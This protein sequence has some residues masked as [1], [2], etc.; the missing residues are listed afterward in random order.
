[1]AMAMMKM[2]DM[3][4]M[5]AVARWPC[6]WE[7]ERWR[8]WCKVMCCEKRERERERMGDWWDRGWYLRLCVFVYTFNYRREHS[9]ATTVKYCFFFRFVGLHAWETNTNTHRDR[10]SV[11]IQ[12]TSLTAAITHTFSFMDN[13]EFTSIATHFNTRDPE[14]TLLQVFSEN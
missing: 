9:C 14:I 6:P 8:Q 3:A 5:R 12:S 10:L 7:S 11:V 2:V 13:L 4:I 1:M